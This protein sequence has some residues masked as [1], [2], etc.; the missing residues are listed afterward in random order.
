MSRKIT[1]IQCVIIAICSFFCMSSFSVETDFDAM[2]YIETYKD[3]A[4][5]E[6]YRK[7]IPA[8]IKLAQGMH[9]SQYGK[10]KLAIN[11]RN[12]FGIKCKNYWTGQSFYHEDDDY[13]RSGALMKSCFRA[14]NTEMESYIDHSNFLYHTN[15]Y[16]SLF[17]IDRTD[18]EAWARGLKECGY[19]TDK[20]YVKKLISKIEKYNLAQYDWAPNPF[21]MKKSSHY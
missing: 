4:I 8:S 3:I 11:A 1:R 12:H 21:M 20:R 2:Q 9:E 13:D 6:M 7:G 10:S 19:A 17:D 16:S 14:Y 5:A 18:Y 15:R